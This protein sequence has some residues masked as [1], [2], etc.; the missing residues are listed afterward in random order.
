[1]KQLT[2]IL[3][4]LVILTCSQGLLHGQTR[5]PNILSDNMCLQQSAEVKIWGWD[6]PGQ[7]VTVKPS[8]TKAVK[9]ETDAEGRWLVKILTPKAGKTGTIKV[10][11]S[12]QQIINNIIFGEVWLCSGQ[13][14]M[15]RQLDFRSGQKAIV[16]FYEEAQ[17]AH[18]PAIRIFTLP[19]RPADTPQENSGGKWMECS[20]ESVLEF[21][22]VAY[23]FGERLHKA[24]NVPMGLINSSSGGSIVEPWTPE[25]FYEKEHLQ[26]IRKLEERYKADSA[27]YAQARRLYQ[28]GA[29]KNNPESPASVSYHNTRARKKAALYNAM[30]APIINYRIKGVIWYQ[31]ESNVP[32]WKEYK[33]RFPNMIKGWREKWGIGDFPFYFVEIAPNNYGDKFGQPQLVEAQCEALKLNNTGIVAT[34]DIG[35]LYDIH[36]VEKKEVS[37]RL[38]MLTLNKTYGMTDLIYA[39]PSLKSYRTDG[40]NIVLDFDTPGSS[41]HS[42]SDNIGGIY[43]FYIAGEDKVFYQAFAKQDGNTM[44]V[45][46]PKVKHPVAVRYNWSNDANATLFNRQGLPALPFRTDRWDDAMYAK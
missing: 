18:Y 13:S 12:S 26:E 14:N 23:F 29:L 34:Q 21:S 35:S 42:A 3:Y 38:A 22:A 10:I 17:N 36:P 15:E 46:S 45:S 28:E 20:P 44:I 40:E 24:L 19:N 16:N 27:F 7:V 25:E 6:N 37:R 33:T 30:I 11:G 9:A 32:N 43:S 5:L 4:L 39:G 1:M 2:R 31:G 41:L 8:W